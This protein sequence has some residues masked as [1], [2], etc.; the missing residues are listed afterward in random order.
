MQRPLVGLS[1][2][3][4]AAFCRA[5]APLF[6]A[7]TVEVVEWTVDLGWGER[8]PSPWLETVLQAFGDAG[9]LLGHGT[10]YS[11]LS[12]R[13]EPRQGAWL[14]RLAREVRARPYR[15][16]SE[17]FGWMTVGDLR[18]GPPL[19]PPALPGLPGLG[20]DR[21]RRL[22]AAADGVPVGLENLALA[23]G[24]RD[25]HAQ[26]D[27]IEAMLAPVDGYLHLDLHNLWCQ[28]ANFGEDPER[29]LDRYPLHRARVLHVSG[30]AWA[31]AGGRRF[32][33]DTHDGAVPPAVWG[34]L[35]AA[36]PRVPGVEAV[37]LERIGS[38]FGEAAGDAAWATDFERLRVEV[39]RHGRR[40]RASAPASPSPI[41]G[42]PIVAPRVEAWQRALHAAL[43]A[44]HGGPRIRA[45]LREP[46]LDDAA[47]QTAA[48]LLRQ[49]GRR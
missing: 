37:V 4:H 27:L 44:G 30:G 19:P 16:L 8:A 48:A 1:L 49:W 41:A 25:V 35:A 33:R 10:G 20:G 42:P 34:L 3:P 11:L 21:M 29:L 24:R 17:H 14:G 28:A 38:A 45:L 23:L 18:W 46:D 6:A 7:Q 40:V 2:M 12:G 43:E 15:C 31:E 9:R 36:L 5:A 22:A 26:P 47:L 32:R 39:A 13:P